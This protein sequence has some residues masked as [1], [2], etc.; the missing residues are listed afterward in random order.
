MKPFQ[1][2]FYK[3]RKVFFDSTINEKNDENIAGK[4]AETENKADKTKKESAK[5]KLRARKTISTRRKLT[6]DPNTQRLLFFHFRHR[7]SSL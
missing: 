5:K 6:L 7:F 2:Y 1:I 4:K 3:Y